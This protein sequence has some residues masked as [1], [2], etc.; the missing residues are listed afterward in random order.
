MKEKLI[1][2]Q[3]PLL[4]AGLLVLL[5]VLYFYRHKIFKGTLLSGSTVPVVNSTGS[6]SSTPAATENTILKKGS[7]GEQ[8]R[9]LQILLNEEHKKNTPTFIPL[10]ETDG[11]FGDKTEQMLLKYTNQSSISLAQLQAKLSQA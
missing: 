2:Y 4:A 9:Q 1:Q 8:V 6:S 10:L 7:K 5:L 3:K 11:I